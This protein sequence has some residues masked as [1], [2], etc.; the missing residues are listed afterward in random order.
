MSDADLYGGPDKTQKMTDADIFADEQTRKM[1]SDDIQMSLI[2][3]FEQDI[4][5]GNFIPEEEAAVRALK[6]GDK[7]AARTLLQKL[8]QL[9]GDPRLITALKGII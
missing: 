9:K 4:K 3:E 7:Q 2:D 5:A 1:V 6:S 8:K